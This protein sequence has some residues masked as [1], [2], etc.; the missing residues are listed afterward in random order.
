MTNNKQCAVIAVDVQ[1]DFTEYRDGSLAIPGTDA[2]YVEHVINRTREFKDRSLPIIAT[3]DYHPP[4]HVSFYTNHPGT[5]PLDVIT[6]EGRRQALWPP[7]CV[8]GTPGADI[9]IPE[10]LLTQVVSTGTHSRF[11]SYSGFRD[12]GGND[13]GLK[14]ILDSYGVKE[15]IIYGLATDYCVRATVLHALEE[16]YRVKLL[17]DLSRGVNPDTAAAAI[18]EMKAAGAQIE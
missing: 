8:Q 18:E 10:D 15:L 9:L 11:E 12:D 1:A 13:T 14:A 3:R 4:D 5:K 16:K 17:L 6:T 2:A 7:H